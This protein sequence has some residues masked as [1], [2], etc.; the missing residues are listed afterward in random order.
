MADRVL[1]GVM[2]VSFYDPSNMS[3][4]CT[5]NA[6]TDEGLNTTVEND[7]VRGGDANHLI[8]KYFYN[9]NLQLKLTNALFSLEYLALKTGATIEMGSDVQIEETVTTTVENQ[10]TVTKTPVVFP[11]TTMKVGS[12]KLSTA[13]NDAWSTITFT[14]ST[15]SVSN[16]PV[17]STVCVRYFYAD[18]SA[19]NFKIPSNIIP[20]IVYAIAKIPEFSAGTESGTFTAKSQIGT[21]QVVIPQLLFDPNAELAVTSTGHATMDLTGNALVNYAGDCSGTGYYAILSETTDGA[22]VFTNARQI[23]IAPSN[24]DLTVSET[25]TLQVYAL[26][27]G[28]TV[29]KLLDNSLITFTSLTPATAT[30]GAH[31]GVVTAIAAGTTIIEAVVT[32]H[33]GLTATGYITVTT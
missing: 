21:L 3:P 4:I 20:S 14:G 2:P 1:A 9:S 31:T 10:I 11:S 23:A 33:T 6:L 26:Y 5:V 16:L 22:D 7:E 18:A 24:I 28:I 17:G 25:T 30:V 8:S 15:A 12:Y 29:N 32:A 27:N 19:R 13:A